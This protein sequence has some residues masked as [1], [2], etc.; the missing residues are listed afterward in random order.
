MI[1]S[2]IGEGWALHVMELVV[3]VLR[4]DVWCGMWLCD[5][6]A[7]HQCDYCMG[8]SRYLSNTATVL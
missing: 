5:V 6:D 3:L 2:I 7:D 8:T 4:M 1:N